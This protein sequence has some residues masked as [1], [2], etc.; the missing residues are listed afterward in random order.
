MGW[1]ENLLEEFGFSGPKTVPNRHT[2]CRPSLANLQIDSKKTKNT[3]K[4]KTTSSF[5]CFFFF[6]SPVFF[7][8]RHSFA[9]YFF[10]CGKKSGQSNSAFT[11]LKKRAS[12]VLFPQFFVFCEKD[13]K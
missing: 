3:T 11:P 13:T 10:F 7:T 8:F 9:I 2:I 6:P 4:T 5:S 12:N 1:K